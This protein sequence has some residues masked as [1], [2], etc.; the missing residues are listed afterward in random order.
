MR[1]TASISSMK[2]M[3]GASARACSGTL[4]N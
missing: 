3:A 4:P 2:M 1:P